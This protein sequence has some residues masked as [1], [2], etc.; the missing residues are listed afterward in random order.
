MCGIVACREDRVHKANQ[1]ETIFGVFENRKQFVLVLKMRGGNTTGRQQLNGQQQKQHTPQHN[2]KTHTAQPAQHGAKQQST[3]P[4]GTALH[5]AAQHPRAGD[6]T[7]QHQTA[8]E[9]TAQHYANSTVRNS[10]TPHDTTRRKAEH[11]STKR[12]STP[13]RNTDPNQTARHNTNSTAQRIKTPQ[14][15]AQ[16]KTQQHSTARSKAHSTRGTAQHPGARHSR[17]RHHRPRDNAAQCEPHSTLH[18]STA[19][20]RTT[21]RYTAPYSTRRHSRVKSSATKEFGKTSSSCTTPDDKP[22]GAFWDSTSVSSQDSAKEPPEVNTHPYHDVNDKEQFDYDNPSE[23]ETFWCMGTHNSN[24]SE[25]EMP[26]L[27]SSSDSDGQETEKAQEPF[28]RDPTAFTFKDVSLRSTLTSTLKEAH[29][30]H[31]AFQKAW[32]WSCK[33]N[34]PWFS[35]DMAKLLISSFNEHKRNS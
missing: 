3:A 33:Q 23:Q 4:N 16:H 35:A 34:C 17:K 2:G 30:N 12:H 24:T 14:S 18:S 7:Q 20:H 1:R 8:R 28:I 21:R 9:K 15:R 10:T 25:E 29:Q 32:S 22:K 26:N 31:K 11:H 19:P 13:H 6:S 5:S 27:E